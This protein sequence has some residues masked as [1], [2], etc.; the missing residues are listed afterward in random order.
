MLSFKRQQFQSNNG[1]EEGTLPFKQAKRAFT[2]H[3]DSYTFGNNFQLQQQH[4]QQGDFSLRN[5]NDSSSN[6]CANDCMMSGSDEGMMISARE[7][8][9]KLARLTEEALERE[10]ERYSSRQ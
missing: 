5:A 6:C 3:Q 10:M 1:L 9:E 2:H 7:W 8:E 4:D